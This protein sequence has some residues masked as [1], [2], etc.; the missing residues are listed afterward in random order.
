[1]NNVTISGKPIISNAGCH[2][3]SLLGCFVLSYVHS[4]VDL[5]KIIRIKFQQ[6]IIQNIKINEH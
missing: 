5:M 4:I 3:K 2:V 6:Y 1:M